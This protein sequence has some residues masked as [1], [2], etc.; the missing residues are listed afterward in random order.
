MEKAG[1]HN[2]KACDARRV[3]TESEEKENRSTQLTRQLFVSCCQ[4]LGYAAYP[5]WSSRSAV[6]AVAKP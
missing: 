2:A 3:Q 1:E 5:R 4:K 6:S